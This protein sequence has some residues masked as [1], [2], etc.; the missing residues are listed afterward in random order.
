MPLIRLILDGD[1]AFPDLKDKIGTDAV[2]HLADET[3]W[4]IVRLQS[5]MTSGKNSLTL[6]I[7][8]PD[9]RTLLAETSVAAFMATAAALGAAE[10]R[11]DGK[12]L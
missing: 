2:V 8:L 10:A 1:N 6:R 11:E 5:G 3:K 9:G 7:D 4:T 12:T